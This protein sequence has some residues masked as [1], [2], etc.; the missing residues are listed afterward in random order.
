MNFRLNYDDN[1][2]DIIEKISEKL[3]EFDL[4]IKDVDEGDGWIDYNIQKIEKIENENI[5]DS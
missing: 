5:E 2:I 3:A 4:I 1:G